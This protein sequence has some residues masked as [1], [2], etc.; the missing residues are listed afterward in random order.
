[1]IFFFV[2]FNLLAEDVDPITHMFK[3]AVA[4]PKTDC[5]L[6]EQNFEQAAKCPEFIS[7]LLNNDKKGI[8]LNFGKSSYEECS[9]PS[10]PSGS[11]SVSSIFTVLD[12]NKSEEFVRDINNNLAG[13]VSPAVL[14]KINNCEK[15]SKVNG[16]VRT[17]VDNR[18]ML[19]KA[20]YSLQ[21]IENAEKELYDTIAFADF[22]NSN[23]SILK[24]LECDDDVLPGIKARCEKL[25]NNCF[26]G[27][28]EAR[29]NFQDL[30]KKAFENLTQLDQ[31]ISSKSLSEAA[32]TL[33]IKARN[34]IAADY[35]YID[36]PSFKE[37]Y[38][39]QSNKSFFLAMNKSFTK[40][41]ENA[42][43][44]L[45]EYKNAS[46]CFIDSSGKACDSG[47][48][49][50]LADHA[51]E[52][53]FRAAG[54]FANKEDHLKWEINMDAQ[55]CLIRNT[56]GVNE[57]TQLVGQ[58]A[59]DV[60]LTVAT[61]GV[62]SLATA[63]TGVAELATLSKSAA[64]LAK[65]ATLLERAAFISQ[66]TLNTYFGVE[67][68][69]QAYDA[70]TG[71]EV[72]KI[73]AT[74]NENLS[75]P[76]IGDTDGVSFRDQ[77]SCK[78]EIAMAIAGGLPLASGLKKARDL[79]VDLKLK[80]RLLKAMKDA[81]KFEAQMIKDRNV[82]ASL[83]LFGNSPGLAA[84]FNSKKSLK[85][86]TLGAGKGV[87]AE[88]LA[89]K[90]HH[91]TA[92]ERDGVTGS[93][94]K[95]TTNGGKIV[96]VNGTDAS[97]AAL[98][99]DSYDLFYE[100]HGANAYS[101]RPDLV[102]QNILNALKK[103]GKYF[104]F[105]GGDADSWALNNKIILAD[106]KV[107]SYLDW[108]KTIKGVHVETHMIPGKLN[109]AGELI[110][111]PGS[112]FVITKEIAGDIKV[113]AFENVFRETEDAAAAG[114]RMVPRQTFRMVSTAKPEVKFPVTE[115]PTPHFVSQGLPTDQLAKLAQS[116]N[117]AKITIPAGQGTG[118]ILDSTKIKL[119]NGTEMGLDEYLKKIPGL[120]VSFNS[121]PTVKRYVETRNGVKIFTGKADVY[122]DN[123]RVTEPVQMRD[124][125]I[126]IVDRAKVEAFLKSH[127][128]DLAG[129]TSKP[130]ALKFDAAGNPIEQVQAPYFFE[131]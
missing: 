92:V 62:A 79:A 93:V 65:N 98:K 102:T 60:G 129:L 78:L 48:F 64:V 52:I 53:D 106:G 15:V 17:P 110:G 87:S 103:G 51:P 4:A 24:G 47:K 89:T 116:G 81:F 16:T 85:I 130:V 26:A 1:M 18:I 90:G 63:A 114:G 126:T 91:V 131:K 119:K 72:E 73:S 117:G 95:N 10:R 104:S 30:S 69:K 49:T 5:K 128:L 75:C 112:Y 109:E 84:L 9:R 35:P 7:E 96:R 121:P 14:S 118:G 125:T 39:K 57:K 124:A 31:E 94:T 101:D 61:M 13:R 33:K 42:V 27:K 29:N 59:V 74:E 58:F 76:K 34:K 55:S 54:K 36:T 105:G 56:Q 122:K 100:T 67:G 68:V 3:K 50:E 43:K 6:C 2:S 45:K 23:D 21:K 97:T 11:Q 25:K 77:E 115:G 19:G 46:H 107:V 20:A 88:E 44:K 99:K 12:Y 32:K 108:I 113:P 38:A 66:M 111:P 80:E 71:H 127:G 83:A 41:R 86:G 22:A 120:S 123:F 8:V 70:C 37:I 40:D 28:T 82:S